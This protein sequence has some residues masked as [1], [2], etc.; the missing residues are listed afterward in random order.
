[1]LAFIL[2]AELFGELL[3]R[4][5]RQAV[6]AVPSLHLRAKTPFCP[7][8]PGK[9]SEPRKRRGSPSN[10]LSETSKLEKNQESRNRWPLEAL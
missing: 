7:M 1:M 8:P 5:Q 4:Q 2:G 9:D 6:Q 10:T 3:R